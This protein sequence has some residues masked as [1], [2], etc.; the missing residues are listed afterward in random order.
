MFQRIKLTGPAAGLAAIAASVWVAGPVHAATPSHNVDEQTVASSCVG[1]IP[2]EDVLEWEFALPEQP[3]GDSADAVVTDVVLSLQSQADVA[4]LVLVLSNGDSDAAVLVG[5]STPSSPGLEV[6]VADDASSTI[7]DLATGGRVEGSA[8]PLDAFEGLKGGYDPTAWSLSALNP[9]TGSVTLDT[10]SLSL[11]LVAESLEADPG[12]SRG[13]VSDDVDSPSGSGPAPGEPGQPPQTTQ[14]ASASSTAGVGSAGPQPGEAT[15]AQQGQ[16]EA[17]QA[18]LGAVSGGSGQLADTGSAIVVLVVTASAIA[19][20]AGSAMLFV[21]SSRRGRLRGTAATVVLALVTGGLIVTPTHDVSAVEAEFVPD[22]FSWGQKP[23]GSI[24][25]ADDYATSPGSVRTGSV[26]GL[27]IAPRDCTSEECVSRLTTGEDTSPAVSPTGTQVAFIRTFRGGSPALDARLLMVLD[28]N[29]GELRE[30]TSPSVFSPVSPTQADT[31]TW[32]PDEQQIAFS[33]TGRIF[34]INAAGGTP[35]SIPSEE[36]ESPSPDCEIVLS[37]SRSNPSW[38]PSGGRI[39]YIR[40]ENGVIDGFAGSCQAPR[41]LFESSVNSHDGER[42]IPG[43]PGPVTNVDYSPDAGT[44][45]VGSPEISNVLGGPFVPG[46]AWIIGEQTRQIGNRGSTPRWSPDGEFLAGVNG[47]AENSRLVAPDGSRYKPGEADGLRIFGTSNVDPQCAP[48]SCLSGVLLRAVGPG[49]VV[50][51]GDIEGAV[52]STGLFQRLSPGEHVVT[53][54]AQGSAIE[55]IECDD[56][57]STVSGSTVT[58]RVDESEIVECTITTRAQN[59]RDRDGIP[60][61]NDPCPD[62][63]QNRCTIDTDRDGTPDLDDPCPQDPTDACNDAVEPVGP[64]CRPWDVEIA[65]ETPLVG[66]TGNQLVGEWFRYGVNGSICAPAAGG[67]GTLVDVAHDGQVTLPAE[68]LTALSVLFTLQYDD[69]SDFTNLDVS[70]T[71]ASATGTFDLCALP[72]PGLGK[73]GSAFGKVIQ[74]VAKW[75][76]DRLVTK[77]AKFWY[78]Q[79]KN[80]VELTAEAL[81]LRSVFLALDPVEQVLTTAFEEFVKFGL[82]ENKLFE[83]SI[84]TPMWNPTITITAGSGL[85]SYTIDDTGV[86]SARITSALN[87]V[88]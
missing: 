49:D 82:S 10:C 68:T 8:R 70:P 47:T 62:D 52:T 87:A 72:I 30:L 65:G 12:D 22:L 25:W 6:I 58:L 86:Q 85:V 39:A 69:D 43:S 48:G 59:D 19:I 31:P 20:A 5:T 24:V 15:E 23:D 63:P 4:D 7:D 36:P 35:E 38:S 54:S 26:T 67:Q 75:A 9:S 46:G 13:D 84:C 77:V 51:S 80:L 78:E 33:A 2:A 32:S 57:N 18:D 83:P 11:T 71:L 53:A 41:R 27:F 34:T 88:G 81:K 61:G 73:L 44:V 76:P 64:V 74:K 1:T 66:V 60:D 21:R 37:V 3:F 28:L 45:A 56:S 79:W 29:T 14:T 50:V 55:R 42:E 40:Q 17:S 16:A